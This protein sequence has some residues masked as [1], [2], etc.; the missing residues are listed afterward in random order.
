LGPG[1]RGKL[2]NLKGGYPTQP[3][4]SYTPKFPFKT[5]IKAFTLGPTL[6]GSKGSYKNQFLGETERVV[7]LNKGA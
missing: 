3:Q 7:G 1:S 5:Q 4:I 2:P 6:G